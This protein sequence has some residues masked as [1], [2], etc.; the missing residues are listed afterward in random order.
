MGQNWLPLHDIGR[1]NGNASDGY[2]DIYQYDAGSMVQR[3]IPEVYSKV[4]CRIHQGS[5]QINSFQTALL[6]VYST[7]IYCKLH[8]RRPEDTEQPSLAHLFV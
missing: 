6:I 5:E 4:S 2:Q 8:R 3:Y 1:R 7:R